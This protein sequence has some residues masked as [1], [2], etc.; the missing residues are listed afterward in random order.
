MLSG[1]GGDEAADAAIDASRTLKS[2]AA[3]DELGQ[4]VVIVVPGDREA[5]VP[6]GWRLFGDEDFAAHP[7]LLRGFLGPVG[8]GARVVADSSVPAAAHAWVVGANEAD[9]HLV[10]VLYGR[11]R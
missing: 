3:L 9:T 11:R 5:K 7:Q 8:L 1:R 2:V 6:S 4:P 10:D